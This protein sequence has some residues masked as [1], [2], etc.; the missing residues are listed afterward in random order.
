MGRSLLKLFLPSWFLP[1]WVQESFL[2]WLFLG[3]VCLPEFFLPEWFLSPLSLLR[4]WLLEW[5]PLE[6]PL[7][8]PLLGLPS[9]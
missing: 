3:K 7:S 9:A 5:P 6:L 4:P 8:G 1:E 2:D